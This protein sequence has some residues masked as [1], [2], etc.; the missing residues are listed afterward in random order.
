MVLALFLFSLF[1]IV[2]KSKS[3]KF[4]KSPFIDLVSSRGNI[5][6][7]DDMGDY[8]YDGNYSSMDDASLLEHSDDYGLVIHH[9]YGLKE[10]NYGSM[11]SLSMMLKLTAILSSY[12]IAQKSSN[13]PRKC[14]NQGTIFW[15]MTYYL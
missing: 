1:C 2:H 14:E 6:N 13:S 4:I 12:I 7:M 5:I 15:H 9:G 8:D 3:V 10:L 11:M